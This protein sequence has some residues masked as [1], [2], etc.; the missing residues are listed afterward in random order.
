M[1]PARDT[2]SKLL[3]ALYDAADTTSS[4]SVFLGELAAVTRST[5][6]AILLH[7]LHQ[8]AHAVSV[9]WAM[10]PAATRLYNEY[11]GQRD[12]WMQKAAPL[13]SS[14]W[15]GTSEEI[16]P[17]SELKR[18]EFYNDYLEPYKM[19]HAIWGVLHNSRTQIVHIGLYR[20]LRRRAFG[21]EHIDVLRFLAPHVSR[22]FRVHAHLFDLKSQAADLQCAIDRLTTGVICLGRGGQVLARNQAAA[23]LCA[24]ADGLRLV[25][26]RLSAEDPAEAERLQKLIAEAQPASG[27]ARVRTA[28]GMTISRR[29]GA[30]LHLMVSPAPQSD[31]DTPAG[32]RVIVF[33]ADASARLRPAPEMLHT[34]FGLSPAES[35]VALL[36]ADGHSLAAISDLIGVTANTLKTQLASIYRKTGTSRQAQLVRILANLGVAKP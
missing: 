12:V 2:V 27:A 11:Y 34:L 16:C 28:G 1:L 9:F 8:G 15:I 32:A 6:A 19:A 3:G 23:N 14:G 21:G 18:S 4:W 35:R 30:P 31:L 26:G 33:L 25:N 13:V 29:R 5:Q 7:D 24:P 10:D 17:M 36:L 20:D 22:A